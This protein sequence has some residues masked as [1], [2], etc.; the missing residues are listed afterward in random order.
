MKNQFI[1]KRK[2]DIPGT[3]ETETHTKTVYDSFNTDLIIRIVAKDQGGAVVL[4]N[5]IHERSVEVPD[6]DTKRNKIIGKKRQRDTYQSEIQI[7]EEELKQLYS[8]VG[9]NYKVE[10]KKMK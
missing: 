7:S 4:L 1:Y 3:E 10:T 5:D 2:V 6:I 8:I 9:H